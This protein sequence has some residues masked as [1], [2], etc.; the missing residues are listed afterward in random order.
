MSRE[1]PGLVALF[2]LFSLGMIGVP[3]VNGFFSKWAILTSVMRAG[4]PVQAA[5]VVVGGL[6]ALLYYAR[7]M[8]L[9]CLPLRED[10]AQRTDRS[11]G[12]AQSLREIRP[13]GGTLPSGGDPPLP[14]GPPAP[15]GPALQALQ[16]DARTSLALLAAFCL[17]LFF[18]GGPTLRM[19]SAVARVVVAPQA[20][21]QAILAGVGP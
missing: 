7:V 17:A 4:H 5:A 19:L 13:P 18:L 14:D 10:Q 20:Y 6:V 8:G 9:M 11:P 2:A 3:P 12:E 16:W 1:A 21:I 15:A